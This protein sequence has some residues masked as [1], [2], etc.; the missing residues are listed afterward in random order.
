MQ[1]P[2]GPEL[3]SSFQYREQHIT[4]VRLVPAAPIAATGALR[5][6]LRYRATAPTGRLSLQCHNTGQAQNFIVTLPAAPA[7]GSWIAVEVD[8]ASLGGITRETPWG[9]GDPIGN[10]LVSA[11]A[12]TTEDALRLGDFAFSVP[13]GR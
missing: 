13:L 2:D 12:T 6:H 4:G 3:A 8:L 11:D 7:D 10:V 1:G 5:F 9:S